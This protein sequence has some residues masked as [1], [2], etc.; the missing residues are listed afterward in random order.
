MRGFYRRLNALE[1]R[2]E[3][4]TLGEMLDHLNGEPL[5]VGRPLDPAILSGL[6]A[7]PCPA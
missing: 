7:L 4:V 1:R 5:P 3:F 6:E 2:G